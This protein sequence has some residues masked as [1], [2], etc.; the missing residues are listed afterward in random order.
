VQEKENIVVGFQ[1]EQRFFDLWMTKISCPSRGLALPETLP[2]MLALAG[3]YIGRETA[4]PVS[5]KATEQFKTE[6]KIGDPTLVEFIDNNP[7]PVIEAEAPSAKKAPPTKA[8]K[9]KR[10]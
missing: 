5:V 2:A 1:K 9:K 10:Q 3:P 4:K 8:K 6:V 7:L